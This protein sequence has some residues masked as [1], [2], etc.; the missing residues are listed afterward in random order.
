MTFEMERGGENKDKCKV[1]AQLEPFQA[2]QGWTDIHKMTFEMERGGENKDKCKISALLE[3]FQAVQA[4]I[5]VEI[6]TI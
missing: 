2:V 4:L 3:Q 6:S 5:Q 1:S